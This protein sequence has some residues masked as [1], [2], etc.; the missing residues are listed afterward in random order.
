M[1]QVT[2]GRTGLKVSELGFGGIPIMR[3][4]TD[5]AVRLVDHC[6]A[7]GITFFDTANGYNDSEAKIGQALSGHRDQVV[8]AT[9][10]MGRDRATAEAHLTESLRR[11]RTDHIDIYQVHNVTSQESL[12]AVL[13]PG[14]V[15][16]Y[17]QR[18][19]EK[20]LIRFIG[21]SSHNPQIAKAALATGHFDTLQ[22]PFNFVE[23]DPVEELFPAAWEMNVG[24]IGMKPLGGG[25]LDRADLCFK[26]LRQHPRLVPIPGFQSLAEA[27][28]VI[29]LYGR[30]AEV[31]PADRAAMDAIRDEMGTRFCHRCEYCL[32]CPSGVAI[33]RI[34]L[35]KSQTRRFSHEHLKKMAADAMRTGLECQDCG[36]CQEKCPYGLEVPELIREHLDLYR[37]LFGEP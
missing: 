3:L 32:P 17:L 20:G 36:E 8:L 25:L 18:A 14:G 29:D 5:E 22:F 31:T 34:L 11:L 16:E 35:F 33:P 37:R 2:L 1:R 6:R 9:K 4:S 27:D 10:T 7:R 28:E 30:P 12:S 19:R 24:V 21:V 26:F 13:A 23:S 15:L